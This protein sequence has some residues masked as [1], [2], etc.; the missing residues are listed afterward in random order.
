MGPRYQI[1]KGHQCCCL[2]VFCV[3][4]IRSVFCML[5]F[6]EVV[7]SDTKTMN[8]VKVEWFIVM[9]ENLGWVV[10]MLECNARVMNIAFPYDQLLSFKNCFNGRFDEERGCTLC[11]AARSGRLYQ[12]QVACPARLEKGVSCFILLHARVVV[13]MRRENAPYVVL[14]DPEGCT[15]S[16]LPARLDF[17]KVSLKTKM[18]L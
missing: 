3:L 18:D 15:S 2:L 6:C 16:K 10:R 1:I 14:L 9:L 17:G 13:W 8:M 4:S 12:Q 5:L 7:V 11:R